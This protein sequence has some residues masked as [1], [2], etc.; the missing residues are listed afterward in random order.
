M[1]GSKQSTNG[2]PVLRHFTSVDALIHILSEGFR[3][4]SPDGWEDKNDEYC[5]KQYGKLIGKKLYALCFCKGKGNIHHWSAFGHQKGHSIYKHIPCAIEINVNQFQQALSQRQM[6]LT[7]I[8]YVKQDDITKDLTSINDLPFV[9]RNEYRVEREQRILVEC[10]E[11]TDTAGPNPLQIP[12]SAVERVTILVQKDELYQQA[13]KRL[14][15]LFPSLDGKI[16]D[17]GIKNSQNWQDKVEKHINQ[18]QT[19]QIINTI[20]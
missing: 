6:Q 16:I 14:I 10:D 4:S 11:S 1:G 17:S 5:V 13:R 15:R 2:Q 18:L 9:K 7:P 19:N 20:K 12:I 8:K 3:F